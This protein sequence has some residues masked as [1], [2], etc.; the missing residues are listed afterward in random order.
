MIAAYLKRGPR[1]GSIGVQ[2]VS[3]Q[4]DDGGRLP[5]LRIMNDGAGGMRE[6]GPP[7]EREGLVEQTELFGS[8]W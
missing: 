2:V 6:R 8:E 5:G 7:G 3:E 4:S 1:K